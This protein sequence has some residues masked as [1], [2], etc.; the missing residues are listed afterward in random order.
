MHC[1]Q[2]SCKDNTSCTVTQKSPSVLIYPNFLGACPPDP[3]LYT[4]RCSEVTKCGLR[5]PK[6][7]CMVECAFS[8]FS[9]YTSNSPLGQGNK[10][11]SFSDNLGF[12]TMWAGGYF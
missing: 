9:P 2:N 7:F 8:N 3:P 5:R 1:P 11:S 10:I 4:M 6:H 12:S